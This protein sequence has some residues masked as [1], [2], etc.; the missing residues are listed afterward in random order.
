[1]PWNDNYSSLGLATNRWTTIYA[2]NGTI[3]TSDA[4]LK[5]NIR[6]IGYGLDAI[7]KLNPVS[8]TWKDDSQNTQRLGLIAQDVQKVLGEVVDTGTD[9]TQTLGINYSEIVPVLIKGIQEQQQQ[10]ESTKQEN[11]MLKSEV[12]SLKEKMEQIEA[13]L[14]KSGSK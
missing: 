7:L 13:L 6:E 12:Q 11:T 14:A 2:T 5:T 1:M 3:N 4:R 9:P 10:I 8:F